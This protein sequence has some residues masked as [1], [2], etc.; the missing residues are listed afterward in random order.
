MYQ[1]H[2][3]AGEPT[4]PTAVTATAV[5]PTS[6]TVSWTA[7]AETVDTYD[8]LVTPSSGSS[9]TV[10]VSTATATVTALAERSTYAFEVR[11]VNASGKKCEI[12]YVYLFTLILTW[13]TSICDAN[14]MAVG[15]GLCA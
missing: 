9:Y 1:I 5:T 14:S 15:N 4:A 7:P 11:G 10:S 2:A 6:V 13:S 8:V 12:I 3:A